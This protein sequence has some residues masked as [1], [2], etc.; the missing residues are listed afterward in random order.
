MKPKTPANGCTRRDFLTRAGG[1][2]LVGA[3]G[4]GAGCDGSCSA[5]PKQEGTVPGKPEKVAEKPRAGQRSKVVLIRHQQVL[6]AGRQVNAKVLVQMLDEGVTALLGETDP[7]RAWARLLTPDDT[8][9]IKSN[10]WRFLRTPEPLEQAIAERA[11]RS[12]VD[13]ER[14]GIDDR[15]VLRNPIFERAT[16]LINV[17]PMRTH[18]WSGV[19]SCIKN[20][21]MF[22]PEP[23]SWHDDSCADLAGVWDLPAVKGKT[24]LNVLVMLTPL[25]HGKGPHHYNPQYTWEYGGLIIG[26]DPVAVD[27]TGVRILEAKRAEHFGDEQPFGVPPKHIQVAEDKFGL[28]VADPDRIELIKLGWDTAALI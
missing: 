28:G 8:L 3:I 15:G 10:V 19:G 17:R 16:A 11:F 22:S 21:I 7:A 27:A 25:F 24:R 4:L 13:S 2:A 23:P 26:E 1:A 5:Q 18:H 6:E 9:G 12:G 20:Y 14:I